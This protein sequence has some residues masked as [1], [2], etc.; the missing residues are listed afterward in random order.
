[1]IETH[2]GRSLGQVIAD[3][4]QMIQVIMNLA[5]N[6]RDA[7]PGGGTLR[8]QTGN[9]DLGEKDS[10]VSHP[11]AAT[12]R[13]ILITLADNGHGMDETVRQRIFEPFFTTKG[14]GTGTGLGLST[15][16]GIIRQSGGWIDVS[17]DV[18]IGTSFQIYL[19][20]T[21]S[22]ASASVNGEDPAVASTMTATILVVEDQEAVRSFIETTLKLQG[23]R[24]IVALDGNM[25]IDLVNQYAGPIHL[26]LTDVIL[27][28]MNGKE[29][30]ERLKEL[31]PGLKVLFTSGYTSDVI[32]R[33]RSSR[34]RH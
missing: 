9:V 17:S 28:G 34:R 14:S 5:V 23:Y 21:D 13:H 7:M 33:A 8:I 30:S 25:A 10:A 32:A 22:P 18:G 1:M 11:D 4:D 3:P 12:G 16:Y 2:L 29:L 27:P 19:P 24:V 20:R 31:R 6:A 26:C 15:V